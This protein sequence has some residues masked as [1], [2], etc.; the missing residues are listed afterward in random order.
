MNIRYFEELYLLCDNG[1]V[2]M[3]EKENL[4]FQKLLKLLK[5]LRVSDGVSGICLISKKVCRGCKNET[6]LLMR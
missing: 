1:K 6:R 2:I 4:F 5:L 3:W